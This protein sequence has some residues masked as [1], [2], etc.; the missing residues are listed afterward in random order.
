[1]VIVCV[2]PLVIGVIW[3]AYQFATAPVGEEIPFVGFVRMEN[4][5]VKEIV[6]KNVK[7]KNM[8]YT[9]NL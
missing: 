7:E 5:N 8:E 2:A 6:N 4:K 1:M 3:L 9:K